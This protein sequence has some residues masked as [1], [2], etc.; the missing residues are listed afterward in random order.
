MLLNLLPILN[1]ARDR[2]E[3]TRELMVDPDLYPTGELAFSKPVFAQGEIVNL[4]GCIRLTG[5]L[6]SQVQCFCARCAKP[7]VRDLQSSFRVVLVK[8]SDEVGEDDD[9]TVY[10]QGVEL[11]VDDLILQQ[12]MLALPMR[13]LCLEDCK[14]VCPGCGADLNSEPCRCKNEREVD[15]RLAALRAGLDEQ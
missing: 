15:P 3:F 1:G 14:G 11:D 13:Y 7:M 9:E 8:Q 6:E 5:R 10:L 2:M 4:T 12:T